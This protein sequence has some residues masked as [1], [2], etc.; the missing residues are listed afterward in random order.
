MS[1]KQE[2]LIEPQQQPLI[3]I[4]VCNC[5]ILRAGRG[6]TVVLCEKHEAPVLEIIRGPQEGK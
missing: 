3:D 5:W 1:N 6:Y 2:S 4:R